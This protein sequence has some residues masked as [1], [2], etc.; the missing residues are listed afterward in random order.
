[1]KAGK[2]EIVC[3]LDRSGSMSTIREDAVGGFNTMIETQRADL[4]A[5]E[6]CSVSV[7][8]FD[9]EYT[10][11]YENVDLMECDLLD[12]T[13][14]VPRGGTALLDAVGRTIDA[15]GARLAATDESERPENV[16]LAIITDGA[17][18][19]SREYTFE[20]VS[21]MI[22]HQK[23]KYSWEFMFIAANIDAAATAQMMN[24]DLGSTVSYAATSKGVATAYDTVSRGFSDRR[25]GNKSDLTPDTDTDADSQT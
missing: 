18:N 21:E 20:A 10:P 1:M 24:I 12:N 13:N 23:T 4:E 19:S 25:R 14:F 11:L 9:N 15:V 7:Y 16:I 8:L 2:S 17:E 3:I 6:E 5:G 22:E